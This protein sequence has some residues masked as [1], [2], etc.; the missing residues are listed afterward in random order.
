MPV[1]EIWAKLRRLKK[2][3]R[4][5]PQEIH[6]KLFS[7]QSAQTIYDATWTGPRWIGLAVQINGSGWAGPEKAWPER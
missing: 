2:Q 1:D 7:M 4:K 3:F 5:T 6:S